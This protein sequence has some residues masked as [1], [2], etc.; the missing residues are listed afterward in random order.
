MEH[1]RT[2]PDPDRLG[3]WVREYGQAVYGFLAARLGD[4]HAADD[5]VQDVFLRAWEARDRYRDEGRELAYLLRIADRRACDLARRTP[6]LRVVT[7]DEWEG[8]EPADGQPAAL[9][10]LDQR[11]REALVRRALDQLSEPQQRTLLLRYYGNLEFHEI[12]E[13]LG[14]SINTALSHGR[15]GLQALGRRLAEHLET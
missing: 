10:R 6:R 11:E 1:A 9:D 15:R 8:L 5:A 4:R 14:C 7:A 13:I 3:R 12:A 2:E